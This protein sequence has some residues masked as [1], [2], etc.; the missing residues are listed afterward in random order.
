MVP[1]EEGEGSR[2]PPRVVRTW[3]P[4]L[5]DLDEC[6][7]R[8]DDLEGRRLPTDHFVD[9]DRVR[10]DIAVR[11]ESKVAEDAAGQ[12]DLE[13]LL[14]NIGTGAVGLFDR[15]DHHLGRLRRVDRVRIRCPLVGLRERDDERLA[16]ALE[17]GVRRPATETVALF[18]AAPL[19]WMVAETGVNP[20]GIMI[21]TLVPR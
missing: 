3:G 9:R 10:G 20:S 11:V 6:L 4:G 13:Q 1:Y 5:G 2:P 15:L 16:R 12:P 8:N 7:R 21:L 19:C 17:R 18:A 14:G